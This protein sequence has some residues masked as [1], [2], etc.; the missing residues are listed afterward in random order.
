MACGTPF[1][2][3]LSFLIIHLGVSDPGEKYVS[4]SG[5]LLFLFTVSGC[6]SYLLS[7]SQ[8]VALLAGRSGVK[9]SSGSTQKRYP[10]ESPDE[11]K[12]VRF[13]L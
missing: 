4:R 11:Y 8:G 13:F 7:Y 12:R 3:Y 2:D 6:H 9:R 5:A 1:S 10:W